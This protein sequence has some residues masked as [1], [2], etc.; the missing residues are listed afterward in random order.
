MKGGGGSQLVDRLRQRSRTYVLG[1][2]DKRLHVAELA[3]LPTRDSSPRLLESFDGG[4]LQTVDDL[5][6]GLE[7]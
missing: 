3:H 4:K 5:S 7:V 1:M 6:E 2:R